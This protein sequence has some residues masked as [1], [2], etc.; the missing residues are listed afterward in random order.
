MD[1][2]LLKRFRHAAKHAAR[3]VGGNHLVAGKPK[4]HGKRPGAASHIEH[5]FPGPD[6]R[7]LDETSCVS[8]GFGA[9]GEGVRAGIPVGGVVGLATR[10]LQGHPFRVPIGGGEDRGEGLRVDGGFDVDLVGRGV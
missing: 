4:R 3:E 6:I 5:G 10:L 2:G 7:Q 9:G 8:A 1:I